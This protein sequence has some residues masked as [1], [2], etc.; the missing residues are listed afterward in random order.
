MPRRIGKRLR[1]RWLPLICAPLLLLAACSAGSGSS[2]TLTL[3]LTGS[4]ASHAGQPPTLA[5][6]GPSDAYAFVYDDQIWIHDAG[7]PDARQLTHL[8]L[9]AG[10]AISWGPLIWSPNGKYI[11]YALSVSNDPTAAA[12]STGPIYVASAE[13]G[14]VVNT[15]ATGSLYGHTYAWFGDQMLF[16][17]DGGGIKMYD[18]GDG[19]PRVWPVLDPYGYPVARRGIRMTTAG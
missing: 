7:K 1:A 5:A 8:V 9:S 11:A 4:T 2:S 3:G 13:D 15:A 6:N 12:R 16:Y 17:T 19:D 18:V 14:S 10:A